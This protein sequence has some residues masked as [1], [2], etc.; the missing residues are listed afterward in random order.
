[1]EPKDTTPSNNAG[2]SDEQ[3]NTTPPTGNQQPIEGAPEV[4]TVDQTAPITESQTPEETPPAPSSLDSLGEQPT[5]TIADATEPAPEADTVPS[6]SFEPQPAQPTSNN[7]ASVIGGVVTPVAASVT[8]KAPV[9]KKKKLTLIAVIVL[10]LLVLAGGSAAAYYGLVVPNQPQRIAQEALAN[11]I[12]QEKM[13]SNKFE[14][15]VKLTGGEVSKSLSSV[16]FEGA[17]SEPAGVE[18]KVG[19]NT[20][21]TKLGLD[22]R[23]LDSKTLYLRLTGLDGLDKILAAYA[24]QAAD[25]ETQAMMTQFAPLIA[26][27]NNQWYTIDDSLLKQMGG[28]LDVSMTNGVSSEDAAKVGEI[29]K[30]HQF[31]TINKRLDDQ[32]IHGVSSYHVQASVNRDALKS[33]LTEVKN[34]NIESL[35][36]EQESIDEIGKVDFS[37]YPLDMWV[38]KS[39]RYITQLAT[40]FEQDGTKYDARVAL[41]DFNKPV[42]IEKPADAKSVLELVGEIA[43]LYGGVL[44]ANTGNPLQT[45]TQ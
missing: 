43:P 37:K 32:D 29:Y 3:M 23:S 26:S 16:T 35:K 12:N 34:A 30:K 10:V 39:E 22:I 45:L 33:F 19:A 38:G 40:S 41:Y 5:D 7:T 31:L 11:T 14:G 15:E 6:P 25:A 42:T 24:G 1:M 44:G 27:I 8:A 17:T 28:G 18:L 9:S 36:L 20:V 2:V 21:V 13:N 4:P